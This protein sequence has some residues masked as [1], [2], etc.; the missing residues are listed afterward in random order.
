MQCTFEM[1]IFWSNTE[2]LR[3]QYFNILPLTL[4]GQ[5]K[6]TTKPMVIAFFS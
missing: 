6:Q 5:V 4:Y 1:H 2:Y 3:I